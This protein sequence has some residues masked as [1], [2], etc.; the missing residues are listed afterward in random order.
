MSII[1]SFSEFVDLFFPKICP[2]CSVILN[3]YESIIC[4]ACRASIPLFHYDAKNNFIHEK[5]AGRVPLT[6]AHALYR[7]DNHGKLRNII[8]S[9]KYRKQEFISSYFGWQMSLQ[10]GDPELYT[11]DFIIPVPLH[12]KKLVK[13][14][15]NQ[16]NGFG[17]Q[18]AKH[19]QIPFYEDCLRR[20]YETET[21]TKKSRFD[22]WKNVRGKFQYIG[23]PIT[24][25]HVLLVDDV[26][27]TGST[28]EACAELLL[29]VDITISVAL[30][31]VN[32]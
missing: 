7:F 17:K 21:Q 19:L 2:G 31:A 4:D 18:L 25:K 8:H 26:I 1:Y 6:Q 14:G 32:F 29:K 24:G 23:L 16:I 20:I 27:T 30:I 5:L 12:A 28:L 3:G 15:F 10:L 9:L 11:F 22:R 13:R